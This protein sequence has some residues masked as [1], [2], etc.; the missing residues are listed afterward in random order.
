M[1]RTVNLLLK[2][3]WPRSRQV[4]RLNWVE[5]LQLGRPGEAIP[6]PQALGGSP[7]TNGN[8]MRTTSCG[9]KTK[10]DRCQNLRQV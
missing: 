8:L 5:L 9:A 3:N 7:H 6:P 10:I 1:K 2:G 4:Y